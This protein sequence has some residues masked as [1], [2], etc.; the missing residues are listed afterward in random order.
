MISTAAR[1]FS[2]LWYPSPEYTWT[3]PSTANAARQNRTTARPVFLTVSIIRCPHNRLWARKA[4]ELPPA[5]SAESTPE[6]KQ[7]HQKNDEHSQ[8]V[9]VVLPLTSTLR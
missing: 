2:T 8:V 1:M 6:E 9:H 5:S 3:I 7:D 4:S